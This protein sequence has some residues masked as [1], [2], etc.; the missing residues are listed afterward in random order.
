ML[1]SPVALG[2]AG[3]VFA[4]RPKTSANCGE[5]ERSKRQTVIPHYW[6]NSASF[7]PNE[8]P[9]PGARSSAMHRPLPDKQNRGTGRMRAS[10]PQ[11][12]QLIFF[13]AQFPNW[14][15]G[16]V[17]ALHDQHIP[18]GPFPSKLDASGYERRHPRKVC[19]PYLSLQSNPSIT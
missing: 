2:E 4:E 14:I 13:G 6:E 12:H 5:I 16:T 7:I 18:S 17:A 19:C 11:P 9:T 10:M 3:H 15:V 8:Q 1:S